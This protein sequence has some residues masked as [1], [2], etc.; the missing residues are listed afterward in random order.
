MNKSLLRVFA[1]FFFIS[2]FSLFANN[3][4]PKTKNWSLTISPNI[5]LS[6]GTLGEYLFSQYD[7]NHIVSDL[8]WN[9]SPL[10]KIGL[11]TEYNYKNFFIGGSFS[12]FLPTTNGNMYDSDYN[13]DFKTNYCIFDNE[14][15]FAIDATLKASFKIPIK[16]IKVS[17]TIIGLYSA[18][19]F[20]GKNGYGYFG[21]REINGGWTDTDVPWNDPR[22]RKA[23][24]VSNIEYSRD[25]LFLFL[26]TELEYK[27]N[28]LTF[29]IGLFVSPI[30]Y[31]NVLDF[32][33]DQTGNTPGYKA[34]STQYGY[35][36]KYMATLSINYEINNKINFFLNV[37]GI[38][39]LINK[40][41][42]VTNY[43]RTG[44]SSGIFAEQNQFYLSNQQS[45][46]N[47]KK[48]TLDWGI[49]LK[50]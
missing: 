32:H 17:P 39:S 33:T 40:G 46:S 26:G 19:R 15:I 44:I 9:F 30:T 50:Y 29:L 48:L 3:S 1:L 31:T 37:N 2:N 22:A 10:F 5:G 36:S 27:I 7:K 11:M 24:S 4:I 43:G 47:L 8:Q 16:K 23:I 21:D 49:K 25:E 38:L 41:I 12:Y 34:Y 45:G 35:F 20:V 13:N 42:L 28:R 18:N 14:S 6:F